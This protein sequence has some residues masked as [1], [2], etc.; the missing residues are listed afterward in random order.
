MRPCDVTAV[1]LNHPQGGEANLEFAD[2]SEFA[3]IQDKLNASL[4][5]L[6]GVQESEKPA[7]ASGGT[8]VQAKPDDSLQVV[9]VAAMQA[10]A[11]IPAGGAAASGSAGAVNAEA[12]E[13]AEN[14]A[15]A[16]TSSRVL[17]PA[18]PPTDS[19]ALL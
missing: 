9:A 8:A 11:E 16:W 7:E 15:Q 18:L 3:F 4:Q 13:A 12:D 1:F 17:P 2:S 5:A 14:D 19:A 6:T 10:Q